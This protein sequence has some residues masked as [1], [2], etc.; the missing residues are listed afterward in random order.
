MDRFLG[1]SGISSAPVVKVYHRDSVFWNY[2]VAFLSCNFYTQVNQPVELPTLTSNKHAAVTGL[3][4]LGCGTYSTLHLMVIASCSEC[5]LYKESI[6]FEIYNGVKVE[7]ASNRR[8]QLVIPFI[9]A[10]FSFPVVQNTK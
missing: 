5:T 2:V 3:T 10:L 7:S 9:N 4:E 1:S 6:S 8:I